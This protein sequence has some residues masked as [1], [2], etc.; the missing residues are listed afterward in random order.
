M[1]KK[2]FTPIFF[3]FLLGNTLFSQTGKQQSLRLWYDKPAFSQTTNFVSRISNDAEWV[4]ALPVGN[5]FLGAMIFGGVNNETIQLNE[6]TLWSGS[7][8]DNNNPVAAES[9]GKI[10]QLLFE[11]KYREASAMTRITQVCKGVGSGNGSGSKVSY[12]SYQTLGDL[13]LDF[14]KNSLYS[15]YK[16]ELD[17]NRGVVKISYD[18]DGIGYQREIF[19]SYPDRALVIHLTAS[20][21]GALSFKARLTRPERFV[22]TNEKDNLMMMECSMLPG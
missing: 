8:D 18:Q 17:L 15:N 11:K 1:T 5:G 10:R 13:L 9:L 6:K 14:G 19:V 21:K 4:K 20:K 3:L 12:G 22:T 16:R 7:P 2:I